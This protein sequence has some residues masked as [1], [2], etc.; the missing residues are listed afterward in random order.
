MAKK[1]NNVVQ[2]VSGAVEYYFASPNPDTPSIAIQFIEQVSAITAE[3]IGVSTQAAIRGS[4]GGMMKGVNAELEQE[5][6]NADPSLSLAKAL[7]KSLRKNPLAL[8]GLQ[9]LMNKNQ[10]AHPGSNGTISQTRFQL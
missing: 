8:M 6:I 4:L 10:P 5:A 1:A 7:P 3:K 9:L 2:D